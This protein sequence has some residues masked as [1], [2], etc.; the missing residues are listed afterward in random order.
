M[1]DYN[2]L[3]GKQEENLLCMF[4]ILIKMFWRIFPEYILYYS[5]SSKFQV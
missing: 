3:L 2:I 4:K 5:V 1:Q